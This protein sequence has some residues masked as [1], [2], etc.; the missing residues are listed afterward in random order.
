MLTETSRESARSRYCMR[1]LTLP[2]EMRKALLSFLSKLNLPEPE[3]IEPWKAQLVVYLVSNVR[4]VSP[5]R[6]YSAT[7]QGKA[8]IAAETTVL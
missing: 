8:H 5:L 6:S 4:S 1:R 7:R 3:D 2:G